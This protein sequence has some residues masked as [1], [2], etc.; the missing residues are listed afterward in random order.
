MGAVDGRQMQHVLKRDLIRYMDQHRW[1]HEY[2]RSTLILWERSR[3]P[4]R[5]RVEL[6]RALEF[7]RASR[8][9]YQQIE[10]AQS[11]LGLNTAEGAS[12]G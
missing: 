9:T 5:K 3:S 11:S 4:A 2:L 12:Y 1:Q 7:M 10:L 8:M 6:D